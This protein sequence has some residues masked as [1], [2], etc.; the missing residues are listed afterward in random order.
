M[1]RYNHW[2]TACVAITM[3]GVLVGCGTA[4]NGSAP[5]TNTTNTVTT[6]TASAN[7]VTT[8]T[9]IAVS[10]QTT[11]NTTNTTGTTPANNTSMT[12][13]NS[14]TANNQTIK[15]RSVYNVET[16]GT[17]YQIHPGQVNYN[18]AAQMIH[19]TMTNKGVVW[20]PIPQMKLAISNQTLLPELSA[21]TVFDLS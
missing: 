18:P 19:V 10:N 20:N 11:Q 15:L 1:K 21:S 3:M 17:T 7:N 5:I 4:G 8:G 16:N 6:N 14:T 12:T 9:N 13:V 2:L